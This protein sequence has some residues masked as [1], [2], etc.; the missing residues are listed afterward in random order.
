MVIYSPEKISVTEG[1]GFSV[2]C[3]THS[4]YSG[5]AF[6]LTKSDKRIGEEMP[7]FGHSIFYLA[8]FDFPAIELNNA[9]DYKCVFAINISSVTF[10]SPPSRTL[11]VTVVGETN[12]ALDSFY[13]NTECGLFMAFIRC[14][15]SSCCTV[16]IKAFFS[17]PQLPHPHQWSVE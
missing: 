13:T 5:G 12:R 9:G 1:S 6:H 2:T 16:R 17:I 3:S 4:R 15:T 7:A 10:S 11:Q 14:C 8:V